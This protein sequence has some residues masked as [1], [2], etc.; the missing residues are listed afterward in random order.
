M[1]QVNLN[2]AELKTFAKQIIEN[3]RY[4]QEKGMTPVAVNVEGDH[5]LGKTTVISQIAQEEGLDFV[6]INV[7]QLDELSDLVGFP[8]KEYQISKNVDGVAKTKWVT[9][10]EAE[11]AIKDPSVRLTGLKR[12]S[13]APPEW[14]SGKANGGI[15][16]LDDYTRGSQ[17]MMQACMDLIYTQEYY[18]WKLPKDWHIVLK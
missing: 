11:R 8:L 2:T 12:T 4:I 3:N 18:S 1:A 16:L 5:G 15:L 9:E 17:I 13:Y 6:K 14:I 10:M 7:A